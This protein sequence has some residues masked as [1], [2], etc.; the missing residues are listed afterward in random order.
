LTS[1]QQRFC[2]EYMIDLNSAAAAIRAGYS[3]KT[4]R[5]IGAENLT[6]PNIRARIDSDI[7]ERS[8]RTGVNSDCVVRELARIAF[9]NPADFIDVSTGA[10]KLDATRDDTAAIAG[11]RVKTSSGVGGDSVEREI[12]LCDKVK[13]LELLGRHLGLFNDKLDISGCVP[14]QIIDDIRDTR[15]PEAE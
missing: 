11:I 4:A 2:D 10:V 13:A 3:T 7:A 9:V 8:R 12:K 14:V 1:K 15:P 5:A 6:K